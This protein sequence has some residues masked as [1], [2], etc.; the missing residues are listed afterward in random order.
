MHPVQ[1][2]VFLALVGGSIIYIW[3]I[4]RRDVRAEREFFRTLV[5]KLS[6][7]LLPKGLGLTQSA[8]FSRSFSRTVATFEGPVFALEVFWDII[9]RIVTLSE[10]DAEYPRS[11]HLTIASAYLPHYARPAVFA[12]AVADLVAAAARSD[13]AAFLK[14]ARFEVRDVFE[15]TYRGRVVSGTILAG[16]FRIGVRVWVEHMP[17][18]SF[19]ISGVEFLDD[20]A[21]QRAW[22]AFASEDAPPLTKLR[23]VLSSGSILTDADPLAGVSAG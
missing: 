20:I 8:D 13:G 4:I 14:P 19:T 15:I 23:Q 6:S 22:V 1:I 21:N 9:D 3:H 11:E 5:E 17:S 12:A 18:I 16:K 7:V 2:A 10:R